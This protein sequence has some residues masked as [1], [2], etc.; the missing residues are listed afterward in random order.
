MHLNGKN[1]I[2]TKS[3]VKSLS[4]SLS[5]LSHSPP[6]VCLVKLVPLPRILR[7][8]S[9]ALANPGGVVN[10]GGMSVSSPLSHHVGQSRSPPHPSPPLSPPLAACNPSVGLQGDSDGGLVF[11]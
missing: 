1:R 7:E 5:P 6:Q 3:G 10:Q 9:A 8:M 4:L 11:Y 2:V